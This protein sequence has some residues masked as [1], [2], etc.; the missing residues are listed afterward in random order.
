MGRMEN[1]IAGALFADGN[2]E[3]YSPAGAA[4][5]VFRSVARVADDCNGHAIPCPDPGRVA[6]AFPEIDEALRF[7]HKVLST[8]GDDDDPPLQIGLCLAEADIAKMGGHHAEASRAFDLALA[9]RPGSLAICPMTQGRLVPEDAG[10][11]PLATMITTQN[12]L[13]AG[14]LRPD[15]FEV[16]PEGAVIRIGDFD[17]DM[18]TFE[19]RRNGIPVPVE[20]RTFDLIS[21]LARNAERLVTK[22]EIF[23]TIW[24]D[25]IVSDAALSSQI[26]A[27]RRALGDDGLSQRLITTIHGRGF[28][29]RMSPEPSVA[30][31]VADDP[32]GGDDSRPIPDEARQR[33]SRP[34]LAVLPLVNL[35]EDGRGSVVAQGLTEDLIN[36][37]SRTRWLAVVTRAPAFALRRMHDDIFRI[38]KE[39]N[40]HY[41]VTGSLRRTGSRVRVT[42]QAVDAASMRC[43]WSES[44]DREM[45][46][47][48]DLQEEI[49]RLVAARIAT[50]LGI[51]EQKRAA[52][53]PRR[54]LGSW[55]LYQLGSAE[56]YRFTPES[57]KRCNELM[58]Q[59]IRLDPDF[60]E[61]YSRL[62][63]AIIL[64]AVYFEGP[65][66]AGRLDEALA[67]AREGMARDDQDANAYFALGRV[68]LARCEYEAAIES[69]QTAV[70][71]NPC[72]ALSYCGL[73]DSLAYEGEIETALKMFDKAIALGPHDPFRWAFM[74]YRALAH[75]FDGQF[76]EAAK[77]ARRATNVPNAHYW[78]QANLVSAL[79]HL[80]HR[81]QL[82]SA[83]PP[84]VAARPGF[85]RAFAR[86][87]LFYVKQPAQ[88]EAFL[89]GLA[90]A[91]IP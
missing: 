53:V 52:R 36:A 35:D 15:G 71:L 27:A 39:L 12:G 60:A 55:E 88:L 67:L 9:A 48:F 64:E 80:G 83:M 6:F 18:G 49:S 81:D 61:P 8:R 58:R 59:A 43:L 78:A 91:G 69:L 77:W 44:F 40:A 84:L 19:I 16:E 31:V 33:D 63:Y 89:E 45:R 66:D 72:H 62:A 30:F 79:G 37:L 2:A 56:F 1:C 5:R 86:D 14:L 68:H 26:K 75:L 17:I 73:G 50:E 21:L 76:E 82:D 34:T 65:V 20:P 90:R 24:H 57:N 23:K 74:S 4:A 42:A 28:R 46:D 10:W 51:T 87:R 11:S 47:I 22:E 29:L 70:A 32:M 85:S 41:L 13:R 25:R 38:A 7:A 3:E 54:N